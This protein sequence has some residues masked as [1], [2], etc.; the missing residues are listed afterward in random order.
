MCTLY[1]TAVFSATGLSSKDLLQNVF[2]PKTQ[3]LF[4]PSLYRASAV[5]GHQ[6]NAS[7]E[8]GSVKGGDVA[9]NHSADVG[10]DYRGVTA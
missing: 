8:H 5:A 2:L 7:F 10:V 6:A 4:P 3:I 1:P 9:A